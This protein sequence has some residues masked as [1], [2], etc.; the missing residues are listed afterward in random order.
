MNHWPQPLR[1]TPLLRRAVRPEPFIFLPLALLAGMLLASRPASADEELTYSLTVEH[2]NGA[3]T[4][5]HA[6]EDPPTA[7]DYAPQL[8]TRSTAALRWPGWLTLG[9]GA[10]AVGMGAGL[11]Y[12]AVQDGQTLRQQVLANP[13]PYASASAQAQ[14]ADK[15]ATLDS[16][17]KIGAGVAVAGV[18]A[19][20]VG[21]WLLLRQPSRHAAVLPT[22][23]GAELVVAF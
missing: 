13:L 22:S 16:Q 15:A 12:N 17:A 4:V 7:A 18:L 10:L 2:R 20:G 14:L 8:L 1:A 23:Q 21:A 3:R 19:A 11:A 5:T 9:A 6:V